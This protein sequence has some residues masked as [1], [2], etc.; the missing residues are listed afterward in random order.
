M[1]NIE[2]TTKLSRLKS[3]SSIEDD[4][5]EAAGGVLKNFVIFT[6]KHLCWSLFLIK[7]QA[8]KF[9]EKRLQ[10]W[11]FP[12]HAKKFLRTPILKNR[13]WLVLIILLVL[14]FLFVFGCL[15][16]IIKKN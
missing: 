12:M 11:C 16:T 4:Y 8:Y 1:G 5:L 14:N 15:F 6:G 2:I 13:E 9:I 7:L 3:V 10:H